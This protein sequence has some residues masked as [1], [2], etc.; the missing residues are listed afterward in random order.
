MKK[1]TLL[2]IVLL[3][4]LASKIIVAQVVDIDGN[5]YK[6]V[7]I[8]NQ[9]WMAENLNVSRFNNGD[10]IPQVQ[11]LNK[12][13]RLKTPAWCYYENNSGDSKTYGKLYNWYA[14]TDKRGL[15][16]EGWHI[17]SDNEFK[18]LSDYLGGDMISGEKLKATT[19]WKSYSG[20]NANGNNLSGFNAIGAGSTNIM[21]FANKDYVGCFW[22]TTIQTDS[23][24][25]VYFTL[26][27]DAKNFL[28]QPGGD[29][30]DGYSVRCL[31][32]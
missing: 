23:K 28:K 26:Y 22:T 13:N 29:V 7:T 8:N 12:W 5:N 19:G 11:D 10:V 16:P 3:L 2:V 6:T 21:G 32:N 24:S 4:T 17:P 20:S 25:P 9:N 18:S 27:G 15:A 1:I 14:I 30:V 31:K